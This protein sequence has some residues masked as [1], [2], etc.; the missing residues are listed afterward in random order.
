MPPPRRYRTFELEIT[1]G[2]EGYRARVLASPVGEI[3]GPFLFPF[4]ESEWQQIS[5]MTVDERGARIFDSLFF[6][7]VGEC[8]RSSL[9]LLSA[10]EGL[11]LNLR[12]PDAPELAA[13]P[14]E[15]LYDTT[16]HHFL[17]LTERTPI[18]RYLPLP[19]AQEDLAVEPPLRV[20][21]I[22]SAPV[23]H[24]PQLDV[25]TEWKRIRTALAPLTETGQIEVVRLA[26]ATWSEL[27]STLRK[28]EIHILHFV[29]HGLFDARQGGG[30]LFEDEGGFMQLISAR[31]LAH[32]LRNH[33][34]LRLA[35]LN[36]CDGAVTSEVHPFAGMAQALVQQGIPSVIA[37]QQEISDRASL[38]FG[39]GFY[40]AV[41]DGYPVDAA[42]A[43]ARMAVYAEDDSEWATPVLFMRAADGQL[44]DLNGTVE[45]RKPAPRLK[46]PAP[47]QPPVIDTFVP[48]EAETAYHIKQ[49]ESE[50]IAVITGLPG[51]GKTTLAAIIA[52]QMGEQL[53]VFWHAFHEA[54]QSDVLIWKL[55]A[56]LAWHDRPALWEMLSN[57]STSSGNLPPPETLFDFLLELLP[58]QAILIC[59]DNFQ[60]VDRDPLILRTIERLHHLFESNNAKLLVITRRIPTLGA[61]GNFQRLTGLP[62]E[63]VRHL[64]EQNNLTFD[65]ALIDELTR[66]TDGNPQ[67]L[68][69]A[70]NL[71]QQ[72]QPPD[73]LVERLTTNEDIERFLLDGIDANLSQ[74]ERD[75]LSA[76]AVFQ[77]ETCTRDALETVLDSEQ[78][79]LRPLNELSARHLLTTR[80]TPNGRSYSEN[81]S[82][83]SFYYGLLAV[84]RRKEMHRRAGDY[85]ESVEVDI[86]ASLR[87]YRAA[88]EFEHFARVLFANLTLLLSQGQALTV[89]LLLEQ[90]PQ[91][92]LSQPAQMQFSEA[93]G[94]ILYL[95]GSLDESIQSFTQALHLATGES[96][97]QIRLARKRGDVLTR[98]GDYELARQSYRQASDLLS[99][100]DLPEENALLSV[101]IGTLRL[102]V[103]EY[104]EIMAEVQDELARSSAA[105]NPLVVAEL[106]DLAGKAY[107][108]KGDL[109]N[110]TA[111]FE[112]AHARREA[113]ND[114][115]GVLRSHSNLAVVYGAQQR[116]DDAVR[117]NLSALEVAERI[118]DTVALAMIY[119]NLAQDY[120]DQGKFDPAIDFN[121]RALTLAERMGNV[122]G[123]G[124]A[125]LN[126]GNIYRQLCEFDIAL[127]H[128]QS[129]LALIDQINDAH[130]KISG[131]LTLAE[132][133]LDQSDFETAAQEAQNAFAMAEEKGNLHWLP[134]SQALLGKIRE[135]QG[136]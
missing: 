76:V 69:L 78:G 35:L 103:G 107:Y 126:S 46:V 106:H 127:G 109:A 5:S 2:T 105:V 55:A 12:M 61:V 117:T 30:L 53:P 48:R 125:R 74:L 88:D 120:A 110:S 72:G 25:E 17:A 87:Q 111:H 47:T 7:S 112:A 116:L 52:R 54:E 94:D 16:H 26:Q 99:Q 44:F 100:T 133:Y 85:F 11:R 77:D 136:K 83:G 104:D 89:Q 58:E 63:Q 80:L 134:V 92:R 56:F 97:S 113:A 57:A 13:L 128:I 9:A 62:V 4:E 81:Q 42:L 51:V 20:L 34:S 124:L 38:I 95:L 19:L 49:L 68:T 43:Q 98:K 41:A 121:N 37:M 108:F 96:P 27:Q 3:E 119:T 101:G 50:N 90:I 14:W 86:L 102:S 32:L 18:N 131:R 65:D 135:G 73:E 33:P 71:L 132:I 82:V 40:A 130:L 79:L 84:R 60:Y 114:L 59:L 70:I 23:D 10:G 75:V 36:S 31:K 1:P 115:R 15:L 64:L 6:G 118:G 129:A 39:P 21:V 45:E 123:I 91:Q 29:G 22:L 24:E 122:H 67:L 93:R 28:R 66:K 8:W